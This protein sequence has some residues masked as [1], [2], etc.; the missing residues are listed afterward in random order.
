[1]LLSDFVLIPLPMAAVVARLESGA[2]GRLGDHA[3]AAEADV[4]PLRVDAR[5]EASDRRLLGEQVEITLGM[6][7]QQGDGR[8][9][10]AIRWVGTGPAGSVFP[11]LDGDLE[12]ATV[13]AE[14]TQVTLFGRYQPPPPPLGVSSDRLLVHRVAQSTV[15]AF[16][17][18]LGA[19]ISAPA[20]AG[21]SPA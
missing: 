5:P 4:R 3:T 1:M 21:A 2:A 11:V 13:G 14:A 15:R 12:L 9:M 16:L 18:R 8:L 6:P 19:A 17:R 20:P 10:L 7:R